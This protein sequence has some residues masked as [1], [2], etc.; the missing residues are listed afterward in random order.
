M[1]RSFEL[2]GS[3]QLYQTHEQHDRPFTLF[4]DATQK[5]VLI[6]SLHDPHLRRL[7]RFVQVWIG[8]SPPT[9]LTVMHNTY[10]AEWDG[11]TLL[12][13]VGNRTYL[14][15]GDELV[16]FRTDVPIIDFYSPVGEHDTP[17]PYAIDRNGS[18]W[19]LRDKVV[20]HD[21]YTDSDPYRAYYSE[22][23]QGE[24]FDFELAWFLCSYA[25]NMLDNSLRNSTLLLSSSISRMAMYFSAAMSFLVSMFPISNAPAFCR[26][27]SSRSSSNFLRIL[28]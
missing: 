22:K 8:R 5:Q 10:G 16:H 19:L 28:S 26:S 20:L 1:L 21:C 6:L 23:V 24:L 11:N 7:Q 15:V 17:Y 14:F 18:K 4:I 3:Y 12:F 9:D 25:S 13:E 2:P 27:F